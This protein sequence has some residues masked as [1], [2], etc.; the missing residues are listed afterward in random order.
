ML[1]DTIAAT[2]VAVSDPVVAAPLVPE[3]P[4]LVLG[5]KEVP[6]DSPLAPGAEVP[7]DEGASFIKPMPLTSSRK[8]AKPPSEVTTTHSAALDVLCPSVELERAGNEGSLYESTRC[9]NRFPDMSVRITRDCHTPALR[10]KAPF[11]LSPTPL[12]QSAV[13]RGASQSS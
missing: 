5:G 7:E 8:M 3:D 1:S 2:F 11:R 10:G 12:V 9:H 4:P 6:E 13:F